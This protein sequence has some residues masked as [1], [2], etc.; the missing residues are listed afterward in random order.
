MKLDLFK[1]LSVP[2]DVATDRWAFIGSNGSG[3]TYC[4]SRFCELLIGAGVQVGVIDT[5]GIHPCHAC[6]EACWWSADSRSVP[7]PLVPVCHGCHGTELD[8]HRAEQQG[9]VQ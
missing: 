9:Q 8:R 3:K 5:A 4:A 2:V 1:E 7:G 6:A